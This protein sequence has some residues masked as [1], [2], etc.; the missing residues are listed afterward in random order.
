MSAGNISQTC[1]QCV[2]LVL[3]SQTLLAHTKRRVW[4]SRVW[5]CETSVLLQL[6]TFNCNEWLCNYSAAQCMKR[7]KNLLTML[8]NITR[9]CQTILFSILNKER[10]KRF[11]FKK[12]VGRPRPWK[13]E[14][15]GNRLR[16]TLLVKKT[17]R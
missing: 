14:S 11:E 9:L 1:G 4:A 7:N 12:L 2:L 8:R 16:R 3:H 13:L 15:L 17:L 10:N 6:S 5:L